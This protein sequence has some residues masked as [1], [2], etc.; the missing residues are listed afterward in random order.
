[1]NLS[2]ALSLVS[3]WLW[4]LLGQSE[5]LG[6]IW[7][8]WWHGWNVLL[9]TLSLR[10]NWCRRFCH[11]RARCLARRCDGEGASVVCHQAIRLLLLIC[12]WTLCFASCA[13]RRLSFLYFNA[14]TSFGLTEWKSLDQMPSV[15]STWCR[16]MIRL[17]CQTCVLTDNCTMINRWAGLCWIGWNRGSCRRPERIVELCSGGLP[18]W[19]SGRF[20]LRKLRN[21]G[22][23][24]L[25][26]VFQVL[27]NT[28]LHDI[29][30]HFVRN[31]RLHGR[32][33]H[34]VALRRR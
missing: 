16:L 12:T 1:M 28:G 4:Q 5:L 15:W 10:V 23:R 34:G 32:F 30:W 14:I 29:S 25:P 18:P 27:S 13:L 2:R 6:I 7:A 33:R 26:V 9:S 22:Y 20:S 17:L 21:R 31:G 3:L 11:Q 8:W 24:P 19:V